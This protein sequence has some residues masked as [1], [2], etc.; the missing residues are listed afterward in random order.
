MLLLQ[1]GSSINCLKK[2][3]VMSEWLYTNHWLVHI[4]ELISFILFSA[5]VSGRKRFQYKIRSWVIGVLAILL[6]TSFIA[7]EIEPDNSFRDDS[8]LVK[9]PAD[10]DNTLEYI[11]NIIYK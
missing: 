2:K 7:L 9:K 8:L 10:S 3:Q 4:V 11:K 1:P 5:L 6:I